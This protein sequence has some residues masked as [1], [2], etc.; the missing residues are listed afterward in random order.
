MSSEE[1]LFRDGLGDRLLVRDPHGQPVQELLVLRTELTSVPAFEFAL[2][3]RLWLLERFDHPAF[4]IVRNIFRAPGSLPVISLASD[5]MGGVR[6][7]VFLADAKSRGRKL[8]VGAA[9]FVMQEI[10][11]ALDELHR[12]S[13]DLAHGALAPERIVIAGG[14][15]HIAD[16]VLGAAIEQL[17]FST[18]RYWKEL[19]VAVPASAGGTRF[20][21]RVDIAQV[22]MIGLALLTSRPLRDSEHIG[23]LQDVLMSTQLPFPIR[24]WMTK[25]LHMDPRRLFVSAAEAS[26]N[27]R[28]AMVDCHLDAA[29]QELQMGAETSPGRVRTVTLN[30]GRPIATLPP[31]PAWTQ[32]PAVTPPA[33]EELDSADP[34]GTVRSSEPVWRQGSDP[35]PYAF[36]REL[37][38]TAVARVAGGSGFNKFLPIAVLIIMLS[39]GFVL[40]QFALSSGTGTLLVESNP[41]GVAV[42]VDG[43]PYGVTPLMLE[44]KSGRHEVELRGPGKPK[45]FNV[46]VT[47]GDRVVQYVEFAATRRR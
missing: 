47:Q 8:S 40:T 35:E 24:S 26:E 30:I 15:I 36:L 16:Y 13:G 3:E 9:L 2:N 10:L 44:V 12:Q 42:L 4:L 18:E 1:L 34:W 14:K 33:V 43:Q 7:S 28:E 21:R 22:G 27:L 45:I 6:L 38:A 46:H 32:E 41:Q 25:A 39:A 29:P 23:K 19:R 5:Y 37:A 17:R 20:D 11:S 31:E